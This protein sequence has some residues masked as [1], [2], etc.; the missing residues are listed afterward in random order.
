MPGALLHPFAPPARQDFIRIVRGEGA[1]IWDSDGNEYVDAMASLWYCNVGH[2]RARIAD[3]VAEQM[4][5]I[6][7]Y[8][9]FDPFT[10]GPADSI[11]ARIAELSPIDGA[12]VF[13]TSSGSEA[14]DSAMKLA[15][16]AHVLAGRP[17][18][19]LIISR[20]RG[21]HGTNYGGTSAQGLAPNKVGF[22]ELLADV[23]QVPADDIESLSRLMK[24]N[25]GR[26]AAVLTEP[27]QG[28]AGVHLPP[29]GYLEEMR[30]LCD[31]HEAFLIFDE[32]ITGFGRLGSWFA[33]DHYGVVPDIATFAKA[34][35]S[36]YQPLGG[37][38]VGTSVG[39]ALESDPAYILR[40]GYTYSGHPAG[41]VAALENIDILD[42]ENL[43]DAAGR[44]GTRLRSGL[45]AIAAEGGVDHVR[46]EGAVF[47]AGLRDDQDAPT[48]RDRLLE[49]GVI[50]RPIGTDSI[51]FCPPLVITDAQ[52]DRVV[53]SLAA[54]VDL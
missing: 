17:E 15:R 28:A 19:R 21:Y 30:R 2:G 45:E 25:E 31:R 50:V 34:V 39:A 29:P 5:T 14:V 54:V 36:G 20:E 32:V 52:V 48:I 13:L 44:I 9:L 18:R 23:V 38:I 46:G 40:H 24:E 16:L 10:N 35:T 47:A 6:E 49:R 1:L 7:A 33:A 37:V 26:I 8:H 4:K 11:A 42:E 41:C 3:A 27:V 22:G 51:T 53:D 43:L 12:R